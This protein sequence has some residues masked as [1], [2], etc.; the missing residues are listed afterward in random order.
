MIDVGLTA[1][2]WYEA[3]GEDLA[4]ALLRCFFRG[5]IIKHSDFVLLGEP[6]RTEG[7]PQLI[8]GEPDTWWVHYW[9][10]TREKFTCFDVAD[11]APYYLPFIAFK[12]RGRI[13]VRP[14]EAFLRQPIKGTSYGRSTV[15]T[16]T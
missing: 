6:C 8:A 16:S 10:A 13:R 7:K 12:R 3:N 1:K 14:W 5:A 2:E 9:G 15:S 4:Q 11:A